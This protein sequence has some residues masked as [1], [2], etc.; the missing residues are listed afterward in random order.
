MSTGKMSS[1]IS[2]LKLRGIEIIRNPRL[3]KVSGTLSVKPLLA[4]SL[5]LHIIES[6]RHQCHITVGLCDIIIQKD[7]YS[8]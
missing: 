5:G 2:D 7:Q 1:Q 3:N 6:F 8:V 4:I